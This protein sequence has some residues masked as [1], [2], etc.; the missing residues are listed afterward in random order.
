MSA[1]SP[2]ERMDALPAPNLSAIKPPAVLP[3]T[4]AQVNGMPKCMALFH[5]KLMAKPTKERRQTT[6]NRNAATGNAWGDSSGGGDG[7]IGGEG[8]G[9][10]GRDTDEGAFAE[11]VSVYALQKARISAAAARSA[12]STVAAFRPPLLPSFVP[13]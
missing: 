3:K 7:G 10:G 13:K 5:G 6:R 9:G 4:T 11:S 2:R 8:G 12:D 1:E